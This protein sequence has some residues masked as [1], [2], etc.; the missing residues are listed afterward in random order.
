MAR[1]PGLIHLLTGAITRLPGFPDDDDTKMSMDKP[2]GIVY[3]DGTVFLYAFTD[4]YA[5]NG[6][7]LYLTVAISRP[8]DA[9]W[10]FMVQR[11]PLLGIYH[12]GYHD[13]KVLATHGRAS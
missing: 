2:R 11:V 3:D 5:E 6:I 7:Y 10:T 13:G 8:G 9:V 4:D 1:L 12:L